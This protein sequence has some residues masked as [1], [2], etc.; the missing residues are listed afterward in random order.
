[1]TARRNRRS[2]V[3]DLWFMEVRLEDGTT[4]KVPTKLHGKGKRWRGR[5]V[6]DAGNEHTKR[7]AK[8]VDAQDWLDTQM[9]TLVQG[10][11]VSPRD[12]QRTVKQWCDEWIRSY[13]RNRDGTVELAKQHIKHIKNEFGD[14]TLSQ[15]RQ[16]MVKAWIAKLKAEGRADSYVYS[17]HSRL[18]QIL[19]DAVEDGLLARNPCSRRTS[20]TAGRQKVYVAT[21]EQIWALHDALPKHLQ[22]AI[23]LGAFVGLRIGEV[24]QLKVVD[25]D[26][27]RGI[28]HPKQ[29]WKD[30]P[31][32]TKASDAPIPIPRELTLLLS[33]SVEK[34]PGDHL[35]CDQLGKPVSPWTLGRHIREAK[36]GVAGLPEGF[37]FHD[38]RH[39]YASL[40]ISK[41][42][43]VKV[44]QAR[45]RHGS[46]M[47]TLG[48][49]THLWPDADES[50]RT[51]VG[52]VLRER[53]DPAAYS[54]RTERDGTEDS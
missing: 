44:V 26:F 5:Y 47:T 3:E 12:A 53:L 30:R 23:L 36:T 43:D 24:S 37:S 46:P 27:I 34:F 16:T 42:A 28:V 45:M 11:H 20:P 15:V 25:V 51:A 19:G 9:S 35:L 7:F 6:D 49:Y 22:V 39:Y 32:K 33:A 8:K 31:L 10:T 1:M 54:L 17:L 21:T 29:Q 52:D 14:F 2:G 40:L 50:T 4:E 18:A 38:L 13:G 41:G 48:I